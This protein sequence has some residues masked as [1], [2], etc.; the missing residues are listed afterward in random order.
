MRVDI[1]KSTLLLG[2]SYKI[3]DMAG[4]GADLILTD[5]P[6]GISLP[7]DYKSRGRGCLAE[8][9]D[10]PK[11]HGDDKAFDPEF[12]FTY[13]DKIVTW[14]ANY[15]ANKLEPS[16]GWL[17]WD[18][19]VTEMTND[20]SDCELAW[21]NCIKGVRI[22]RHMWNGFLRDSERGTGFHATQKP[23]AL[24]KWVL[25]MINPTSVLDPFMGSGP[26]G[27]AC[28]EMGIPY[29]GIEIDETYFNTAKERI[30]EASKQ[31]R[32]F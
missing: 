10:Y 24:M 2:D 29:I 19:R 17:V 21:T 13:S 31:M 18:K 6:Y 32:L 1:G 12:L 25:S 9:R 5:P 26:V 7:T 15:Y 30:T 23:V 14:G 4:L 3:L 22:F 16:N 20:Q 8:N 11:V 27:V 28:E